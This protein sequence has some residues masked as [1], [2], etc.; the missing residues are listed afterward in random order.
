MCDEN[1]SYQ[2]VPVREETKPTVC[3]QGALQKWC[4]LQDPADVCPGGLTLLKDEQSVCEERVF[5]GL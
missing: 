2:E 5:E 1:V 3:L 4:L